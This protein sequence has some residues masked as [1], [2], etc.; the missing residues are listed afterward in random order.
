MRAVLIDRNPG[1]PQ[2]VTAILC[3]CH[4]DAYFLT[5]FYLGDA[6]GR[7]Q[8]VHCTVDFRLICVLFCKNCGQR[9]SLQNI[10]DALFVSKIVAG[11]FIFLDEGDIFRDDR[12]VERIGR[13]CDGEI[14]RH[15]IAI[16]Q[17][18]VVGAAGC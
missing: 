5:E 6:M 17:A 10:N 9:V 1:R 18:N 4:C 8:R 15:R 14:V 13:V 7:D 11:I 3:G 12:D 16:R 2:P